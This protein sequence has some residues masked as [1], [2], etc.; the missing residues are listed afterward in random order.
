M[1]AITLS[2]PWATLVAIGAKQIETRSWS[3]SYRGPIAIHAG[4]GL[5]PVNGK[6]GL[7]ALCFSNPFLKVLVDHGIHVP[8]LLE[9]KTF[10]R[11]FP[12]G[13][14]IAIAELHDVRKTSYIA[15]AI[16]QQELAFGDYGAGR[17][18]WLLR[19]VQRLPTAVECR[20]AL[21]LWTVPDSIATQIAHLQ[22]PS[23]DTSHSP[24][25]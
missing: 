11:V 18:A 6:T 25:L 8:G 15:D 19:N 21:S 10:A 20:G 23:F 14:I 16:S 9:A 7:R 17:Y 24:L 5:E 22:Q 13:A 3:T 1:K 4:K 12:F 2:Q